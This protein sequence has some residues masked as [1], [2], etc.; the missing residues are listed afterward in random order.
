MRR[1]RRGRGEPGAIAL[2]PLA[3]RERRLGLGDGLAQDRDGLA[4]LGERRGQL[5]RLGDARLERGG[6][7][8][9]A[10]RPPGRQ[11]G[12][13]LGDRVVSCSLIGQWDSARRWRWAH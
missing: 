6:A 9:R 4:L 12:V 2:E 3:Q 10:C 13:L 7:L 8:G 5:G 11:L 1:R